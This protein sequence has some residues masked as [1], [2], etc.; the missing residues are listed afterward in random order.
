MGLRFKGQTAESCFFVTT[1]YHKHTRLG[2]VQGV[3]NVLADSLTFCL[4]KYK[5]ALPSYV[6]MPSHLHL[7]LMIDGDKLAGFMRDFKKFIAQK[8]IAESGV[9][10]GTVWQFRYDRV[11]VATEKTFLRKLRYIH[12]NPVR[13]GLCRREDEW[14]WSSAGAYLNDECGPVP[15]WKEWQ[16]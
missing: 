13:A 8:G 15:V 11:V 5:A 2:N 7:L 6:L 10:D 3:N 4:E 9:S 1:S 14:V 12:R 16:F